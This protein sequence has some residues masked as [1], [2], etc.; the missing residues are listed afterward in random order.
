MKVLLGVT[1]CIAAYKSCEILRELQKKGVDVE[2]VM[3]EKATKFIGAQTFSAL[4]GHAAKIS[5][6]DDQEDAITHIRLAEDCDLFLIAPCTANVA[7]K[8]AAGIGDDLLTT[9]A[10]VAHDKLAIAPAMNVHMYE[11]PATQASLDVLRSRGVCIIEPDSGYLACGDVGKGRL[12]DPDV[13]ASSAIRLIHDG[14]ASAKKDLLGKKVVI[15]AGP[16]QERIDPVRYITNDSSGK[17]GIAIANAAK[18]RGADVT[19]V[20]GPVSIEPDSGIKVVPVRTAEDM[21]VAVENE[22]DDSD[23]AIFTAAVCDMKP[24]GSYDRKLKKGTDDD[25]LSVIKTENTIDILQTFASK[26]GDRFIVGFAAETNDVVANG[27]EKLASKGADMIVANEVGEGKTFGQDESK[28]W[29]LEQN[30]EAELDSMP[31]T[32]LAD[33]ILDEVCANMC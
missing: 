9:C 24:V 8:I 16:T 25:G 26:K 33:I 20:L 23:I 27:K 21:F 11:S 2:V 22:F 10:L 5:N 13:I 17:M 1:G 7:S 12:A 4:S 19:L 32:K 18:N 3:T 29:I 6:F 28:A 31:K 15:T 30:H 14:A